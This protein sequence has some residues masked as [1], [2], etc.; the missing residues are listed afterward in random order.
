MRLEN[1]QHEA[2][3][4]LVNRSILTLSFVVFSTYAVSCNQSSRLEALPIRSVHAAAPFTKHTYSVRELLVNPQSFAHTVVTVSGR[5]VSGLKRFQDER[6]D[7]MR[8]AVGTHLGRE[9]RN[10]AALERVYT[11]A[12]SG[13]RA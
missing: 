10:S 7:R 4:N 11:F 6:V 2:L 9:W 12:P 1:S 3:G 5:Y 13:G 8:Q